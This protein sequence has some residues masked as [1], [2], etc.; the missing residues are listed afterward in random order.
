MQDFNFVLSW[1]G[2]NLYWNELGPQRCKLCLPNLT[3][4]P[5]QYVI[6]LAG[7]LKHCKLWRCMPTPDLESMLALQATWHAK[8]SHQ[9]LWQLLPTCPSGKQLSCIQNSWAKFVWAAVAQEVAT[10]I[11]HSWWSLPHLVASEPCCVCWAH[12]F[13]ILLSAL[14][15]GQKLVL[16]IM[17]YLLYFPD[18]F[19]VFCKG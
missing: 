18:I 3:F 9:M 5:F 12:D 15:H 4:A 10:C 1:L 11:P 14:Q 19:P 8:Q 17:Q 13:V 16:H 6:R 2:P 7:W